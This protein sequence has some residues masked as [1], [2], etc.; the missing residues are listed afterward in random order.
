MQMGARKSGINVY[1][2]SYLNA[3]YKGTHIGR[4]YAKNEIH[5][6]V[7]VVESGPKKRPLVF[8]AWPEMEQ[9]EKGYFFPEKFKPLNKSIGLVDWG[10]EDQLF[11][12]E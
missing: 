1:R 11:K 3:Y 12:Y 8:Y 10:A 7:E 5:N 6:F 4:K 2:K 9:P